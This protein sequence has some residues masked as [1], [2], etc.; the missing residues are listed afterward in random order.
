VK[1]NAAFG[2]SPPAPPIDSWIELSELGLPIDA[3]LGH[4]QDRFLI[5]LRSSWSISETV[6]FKQGSL[7]TVEVADFVAHG[8]KASKLVPLFVPTGRS[9]LTDFTITKACLILQILENVKERFIYYRF[10]DQTGFRLVSE[11]IDGAVRGSSLRAVDDDLSDEIWYTTSSFTQ[12]SRLYIADASLGVDALPSAQLLKSLPAMFDASEL[13]EVQ[14]EA[15]SADGTKIP[16][17][18]IHRRDLA[19]NGENPTLLYGYG[20]FEISLTPTYSSIVGYGWLQRGGVFAYANIRGGGEFGPT[21]HQA[22][23]RQNRK[24]AYDDFIAVA[25]DL[26]HKKVTSSPR[27]GIR[28]G[29]NGGLLMGN[30]IT[31]RPDLFGAVVCAVPLLDMRRY[32]VLLA[33]ASWMAEYGNPD[34]AEDWS[35]L[36]HY[37]A[38]H[39][40]D[41][42]AVSTGA[43]PPLLMTTSTKDDRVHPYHARAFVKRLLDLQPADQ[44]TDPSSTARDTILKNRVLYYE[45]MEGGHG[46][47]A[48]NPQQAFMNALYLDFLW[49]VLAY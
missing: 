10:D 20:G 16:Y 45:N 29:S 31:R 17:F 40:I 5:Q 30:M 3:E 38:Y 24:L 47:A 2:S 49:K 42:Q 22:A 7:L 46:G 19:L 27:L 32:N 33:G 4:F 8:S 21:W 9:S 12:P 48:D 39:N 18:L 28:G 13:V 43:Y 34:V 11:E 36:R 44:A 23:L 37:S 15:I 26:I 35:F 1:L 6:T 25:E 41:M 14:H